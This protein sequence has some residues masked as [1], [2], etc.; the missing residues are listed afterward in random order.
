ML[1]VYL[2]IQVKRFVVEIVGVMS[3]DWSD[4]GS[5]ESPK[6]EPPAPVPGGSKVDKTK[7]VKG[8]KVAAKVKEPKTKAVPVKEKELELLEDEFG[9]PGKKAKPIPA[10]LMKEME[11][12]AAVCSFFVGVLFIA[13][14]ARKNIDMKVF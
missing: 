3:D 12:Q 11:E 7:E 9:T 13:R 6:Q 1:Y 10:R 14:R 2:V 4:E 8:K 5:S